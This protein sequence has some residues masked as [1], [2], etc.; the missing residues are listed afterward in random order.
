MLWSSK[1]CRGPTF[2]GSDVFI[3][4]PK[5]ECHICNFDTRML[6]H[7]VSDLIGDIKVRRVH[8]AVEVAVTTTFTFNHDVDSFSMRYGSESSLY[9]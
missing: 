8:C 1:R 3:P 9:T 4:I 5:L 2:I 7:S 6:E